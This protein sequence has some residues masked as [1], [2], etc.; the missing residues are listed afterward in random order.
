MGAAVVSN[1]TQ[2]KTFVGKFRSRIVPE[3]GSGGPF[4]RGDQAGRARSREIEGSS[5]KKVV[6]I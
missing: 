3:P 5:H 1:L 6:A 4:F 2:R